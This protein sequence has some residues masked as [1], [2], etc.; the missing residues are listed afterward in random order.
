MR[1]KYY[2]QLFLIVILEGEG[3]GT[4]GELIYNRLNVSSLNEIMK[5]ILFPPNL[6]FGII[7]ATSNPINALNL[8][9]TSSY[10][11]L[12]PSGPSANLNA[13]SV[14]SFPVSGIAMGPSNPI[15]ILFSG[16]SST[17]A[18]F[19]FMGITLVST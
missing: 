1:G 17:W 13:S 9:L 14:Y 6:I 7:L 8:N 19:S 12:I 3:G 15:N 16:S 18:Y 4:W 11:G 5:A 10:A 2:L